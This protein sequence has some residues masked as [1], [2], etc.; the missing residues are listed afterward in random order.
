MYVF[1]IYFF[2]FCKRVIQNNG[3]AQQTKEVR[4][5]LHRYPLLYSS[6]SKIYYS[7]DYSHIS[8]FSKHTLLFASANKNPP[9]DGLGLA[10]IGTLPAAGAWLA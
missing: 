1:E 6:S 3:K 8:C 9:T 10:D 5:F 4:S 7:I 2:Y